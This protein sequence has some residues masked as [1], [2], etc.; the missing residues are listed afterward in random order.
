MRESIKVIKWCGKLSLVFLVLTYLVSV[1]IEGDFI[2][3]HTVWLSNTFLL[4]LFGGVFASM[5]VVVLCEIQKYLSAKANIEQFL[6]Y[7]GLYLYQAL[8]Q[9]RVIALDYLEHKEWIIPENLFDESVRMIRGE[10]IALQNTD[11]ATFKQQKDTLA[12]VHGVFRNDTLRGLQPLLQSNI[13]LKLS[14]NQTQLDDLEKQRETHIYHE[15]VQ[16]VSSEYHR[17]NK[18]LMDEVELLEEAILSVD[19]YIGDVDAYCGKRF[20]WDKIKKDLRNPHIEELMM[21]DA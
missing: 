8:Q 9:M 5:L 4:T 16:K 19:K 18:I 15:G 14:I 7:Q 3:F 20:E 2:K 12:Y 21:E 1:N 17:V 13:R 6:F 10:M 11:Y